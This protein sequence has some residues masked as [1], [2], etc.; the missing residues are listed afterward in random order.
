M[1]PML[2]TLTT[3]NPDKISHKN[4]LQEEFGILQIYNCIW[5]KSLNAP[6]DLWIS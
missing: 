6:V 2:Q 4:V 5:T 3:K 1:F